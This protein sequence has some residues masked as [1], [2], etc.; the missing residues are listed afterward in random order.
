MLSDGPTRG[1]GLETFFHHL[2]DLT[3]HKTPTFHTMKVIPCVPLDIP[4]HSSRPSPALPSSTQTGCLTK[5][6]S[7]GRPPRSPLRFPSVLFTF[8]TQRSKGK[9][10]FPPG[11]YCTVWLQLFPKHF[12]YFGLEISTSN[13]F[14]SRLQP[15]VAICHWFFC[16]SWC[17]ASHQLR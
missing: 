12:T 6:S 14:Q 9:C 4:E 13:Q 17:P 8:P 16:P 15:T 3:F 5:G 7:V 11:L 2:A 10:V 1:R